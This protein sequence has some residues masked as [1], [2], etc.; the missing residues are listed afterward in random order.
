MPL[1]DP[2]RF[3]K[4]FEAV[5]PRLLA[6]GA[7]PEDW[8]AEATT[9]DLP[10]FYSESAFM[11]RFETV[12]QALALETEHTAP[13]IQALLASCGHPY[14]YARL[15]HPLS[16]LYEHY[17]EA[18]SGAQ[19]AI[20][21]ASQT[22]PFL[23]VIE[24]RS[25]SSQ[26][27]L[28]Y[29]PGA[30]PLSAAKKQALQ[31]QQV[32]IHE[33][34]QGPLP[35]ASAGVSVYVSDAAVSQTDLNSL[36]ADAVSFALEAGG[37]LL[38]KSER[39]D[40][41][42]LQ[43]IRKRT[44][45]ALLSADAKAELCRLAGLPVAPTPEVTSADCD[46]LLRD[47]F[48]EIC[49]SAY[50]CTGLAAE[51]AVFSST[52]ALLSQGKPVHILY[53]EN[54]YG[55]TGQLIAELLPRTTSLRP[56]PLPVLSQD[57]TGQTVTLVER[58]VASLNSLDG[59]P[60]CLFLETP[61]NPELQ[62]HDFDHLLSALKQYHATYGQQIPLLVDTTLAPL[63]PLLA[64]DFAQNWP[65]VIVK[66]GSKYFTK[67]K[68]ILGLALAGAHPLA[69]QIVAEARDAA[70]DSDTR[71]KSAQL[72]A[73]RAGLADLRPRMAQI[74]AHTRALADGIRAGLKAYGHEVILY[75]IS[76]LPSGLASGVLSFYLPAAPSSHGDLVDE[77]V[78]YLLLH[79]PALVK[80]RVSY[81]QAS[82]EGRADVF[83][84]INPEESTQGSLSEAVKAAQKRDNVQICRI[85]VPEHANVPALLHVMEAFFAR[86]YAT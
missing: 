62:V 16:T 79:A 75:S 33:N 23:A 83:Y 32:Q 3:L 40:P 27:V 17:L 85:S 81:G 14:D 9:Y 50:F 54:G 60:A 65:C 2:D 76:D 29:A 86:K 64:Q 82:P 69:R 34:W 28:L 44:A 77:F 13:Q 51:A 84:V 72:A 45:A 52:A 11:A 38:L 66:S 1:S 7:L 78:D 71:A 30:L 47:V 49:E 74:A 19:R 18:A 58:M 73:L 15:G 53:A 10:R 20:S 48:P 59:E 43:L 61:T 36:N 41:Q 63:Y 31:D 24:A 56:I 80:N 68:A 8:E 25:D 57:A 35:A 39:I 12:L 42:A 21:F 46:A 55:G 22:K 5:L 6:P 37:V 4:A 26:P 70:R 67:G